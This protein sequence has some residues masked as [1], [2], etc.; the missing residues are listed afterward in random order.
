MLKEK[1]K[2]KVKGVRISPGNSKLGEVPNIS[3]PPGLTCKE[4]VSC[5][6]GGCF[7][8]RLFRYPRTVRAWLYNLNLWLV[9]PILFKRSLID[10]LQTNTPSKFRWHVGGDLPD[11]EY[12]NMV[13]EMGFRFPHTKF[14]I[15]TKRTDLVFP[16]DAARIPPNLTLIFSMWPGDPLPDPAYRLNFAFSWLEEDER[17]PPQHDICKGQCSSCFSCWGRKDKDIIFKRH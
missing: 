8:M 15:F 13:I 17:K 12:F 14:L 16:R 6:T 7:A 3:L 11:R 2:D 10:Y 5:R 9:D 1:Q 4:S